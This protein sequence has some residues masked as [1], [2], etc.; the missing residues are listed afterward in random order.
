M[1]ESAERDPRRPG[2]EAALIRG[3][4]LA[5]FDIRFADGLDYVALTEQMNQIVAQT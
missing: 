4:P 5:D 2:I 3:E 1:G